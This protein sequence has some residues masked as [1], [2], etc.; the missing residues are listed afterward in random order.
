MQRPVDVF[1]TFPKAI[2]CV[3]AGIKLSVSETFSA[4]VINVDYDDGDG[5]ICVYFNHGEADAKDF[6]VS[7]DV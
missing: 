7:V 5:N 4:S 2:T 6:S 3:M 1:E